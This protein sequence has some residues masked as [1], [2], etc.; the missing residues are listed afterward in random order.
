MARLNGKVAIVTGSSK[1]IGAAIAKG[2]A[3]EGA[4]VVVNYASSTV[5]ANR[6]VEEITSRGGRA[7]AIQADVS[8]SADIQR[9]FQEAQAAFGTIN[10]LVNNAGVYSFGPLESVTEDEFHR[11]MNTNVL[12][13][14]LTMQ[15]AAQHFGDNGG[16]II[17]IASAAVEMNG[18]GTALYTATKSAIV[19][20]TK[21][22]S[23]EL[24][25]R[26]IRVNAVAPGATES[27]GLH[28]L[29]IFG[30]D[31]LNGMIA[32]TP[33]GRLG[34]PEDIAPVAVF[35]ASDDAAWVTGEVIFASG[36]QR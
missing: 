2:L 19:A 5:D 3:A 18:P 20:M 16:S 22:L 25:P 6:V 13:A 15:A 11:Q 35:L 12:G 7:I 29:G 27:E 28:A 4:A 36:G 23:K 31:F 26:H 34:Q 30:S 33:L 9:L 32:Q 10:V 17:N 1:G 21:V 8:K 14:F 24:G